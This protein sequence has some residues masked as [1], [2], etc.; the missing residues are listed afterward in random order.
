MSFKSATELGKEFGLSYQKVNKVLAE[1]NLYDKTTRRPTEYAFE[2]GLAEMKTTVSRFTGK[3]VE[4]IAWD[5][6][7]LE[8]MFSKIPKQEKVVRCRSS[9]DAFNKICDAFADFGN[10]MNIDP[11][12]QKKGIGKEA[13]YAVVQ[14]YFGDPSYLRGPLLHG[15]HFHPQEAERV[16]YI[17][18]TLANELFIEAKKVNAARAQSNLRTIEVVMQWLCDKAH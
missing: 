12:K 3:T 7:K 18:L 14:A 11:D 9:L 1:E 4:Y 8:V 17:T 5:F 6:R 15:R 16:K 2:N 10:M 13:H